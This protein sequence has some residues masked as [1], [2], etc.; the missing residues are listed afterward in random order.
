MGATPTPEG[1]LIAR[2][3]NGAVL[4][5]LSCKN[6]RA[7]KRCHV[8]RPDEP[9]TR[10]WA[11]GR[12]LREARD[13]PPGTP[14]HDFR[15]RRALSFDAH[16]R[17]RPA[18]SGLHADWRRKISGIPS[19]AVES[20]GGI[21]VSAFA[22]LGGA[23]RPKTFAGLFGAAPSGPLTPVPIHALDAQRSACG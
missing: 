5:N 11:S 7:R 20:A 15:D 3:P 10:A 9:A 14:Q 2:L 22:A 6:A 4:K 19:A 13:A 8:A 1:A 23:I 21:A 17:A 16:A 18:S 12:Y